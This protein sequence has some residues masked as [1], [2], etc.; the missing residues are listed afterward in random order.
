MIDA[1]VER[2]GEISN[3]ELILLCLKNAPEGTDRKQVTRL[4]KQYENLP[5]LIVIPQ[6]GVL[7]IEEPPKHLEG[8]DKLSQRKSPW[9]D[10]ECKHST[11]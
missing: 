6:Q 10:D 8:L 4:I 1:T 2:R 3:D 7:F 9:E 5:K 11:S